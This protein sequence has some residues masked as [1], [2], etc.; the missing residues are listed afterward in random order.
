MPWKIPSYL[1]DIITGNSVP[2]YLSEGIRSYADTQAGGCTD[3]AIY[4]VPEEVLYFKNA[5]MKHD[6]PET[7]RIADKGGGPW[8]P[9]SNKK[10]LTPALQACL[11]SQKLWQASDS[12][13]LFGVDIQASYWP[14]VA[15]YPFLPGV[16]GGVE[17]LLSKSGDDVTQDAL[18]RPYTVWEQMLLAVM[19]EPRKP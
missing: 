11:T 17:A 18:A 16:P 8:F 4:F 10:T 5:D 9:T 3:P 1:C 14:G 12:A 19:E 13:N 7:W 15:G 6:A 2:S